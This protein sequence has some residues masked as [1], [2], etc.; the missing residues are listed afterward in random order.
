MREGVCHLLQL[1]VLQQPGFALAF[2][3]VQDNFTHNSL[4]AFYYILWL[5]KSHCSAVFACQFVAG[6]LMDALSE[7][8][9]FNR[10]GHFKQSHQANEIN[11]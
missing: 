7:S 11:K 4:R 2:S 9:L 3:Q 6:P 5:F 8:S 1:Q 10:Y